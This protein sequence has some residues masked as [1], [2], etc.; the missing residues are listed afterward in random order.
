MTHLNDNE[1]KGFLGGL[2]ADK[3]VVPR[4]ARRTTPNVQ[5]IQDRGLSL[6]PIDINLLA[7]AQVLY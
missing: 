6:V 2:I 1:W 4:E 5:A 7:T 3:K